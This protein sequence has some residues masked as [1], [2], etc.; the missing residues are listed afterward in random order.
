MYLPLRSDPPSEPL[1]CGD[2]RLVFTRRR[3]PHRF[4]DCG[5]LVGER[6]KLDAVVGPGE[7]DQRPSLVISLLS[8][9]RPDVGTS[10]TKGRCGWS[11]G[12]EANSH[13]TMNVGPED[14]AAE[15]RHRVSEITNCMS[16]ERLNVVPAVINPR[17]GWMDLGYAP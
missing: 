2:P 4:G 9:R 5:A 3:L 11:R 17:K 10:A 13:Y 14:A 12:G 15:D 7:E 16:W 1:L 6:A 8:R